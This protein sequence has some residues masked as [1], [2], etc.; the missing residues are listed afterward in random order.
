MGL[1]SGFLNIPR[2]K[3]QILILTKIGFG[4]IELN[5][6]W[7]LLVNLLL[8][9]IQSILCMRFENKKEYS[10]ISCVIGLP[11]TVRFWNYMN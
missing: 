7:G 3:P 5:F 6:N 4:R 11:S 10:M 9:L 8:K 1:L 2:Q